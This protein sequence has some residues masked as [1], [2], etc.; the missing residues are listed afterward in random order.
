MSRGHA[1]A[2]DAMTMSVALAAP[3]ASNSKSSYPSPDVTLHRPCAHHIPVLL[4]RHFHL[5]LSTMCIK[6]V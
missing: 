6:A 1:M 5:G 2:T 3:T 4:S